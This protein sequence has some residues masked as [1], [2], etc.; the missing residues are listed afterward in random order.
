MYTPC[1]RY[2]LVSLL[3]VYIYLFIYLFFVVLIHKPITV[4]FF[5][6]NYRREKRAGQKR[7]ERSEE[8]RKT[9]QNKEQ[10]VNYFETRDEYFSTVL[11]DSISF[12][13]LFHSR[14]AQCPCIGTLFL[15]LFSVCWASIDTIDT[16]S[17]SI[18]GDVSAT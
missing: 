6:H 3:L 16:C 13:A 17:H 12:G 14:C 7:Q 9:K 15:P 8:E 1:S 18:A 2:Y 5:P 4:H 11:R 10:T